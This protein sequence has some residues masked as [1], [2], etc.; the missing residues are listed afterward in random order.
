MT[1]EFYECEHDGDVRRICEDLESCGANIVS[2]SLN[3]ETE[4][5]TITFK[6]KENSSMAAFRRAFQQTESYGFIN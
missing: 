6:I 2:T 4:I 3:Q 5:A 1:L